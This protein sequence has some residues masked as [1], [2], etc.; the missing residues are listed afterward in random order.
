[1]SRLI[2]K[3]S[4]DDIDTFIN[5]YVNAY[6]GAIT[7]SFSKEKKKEEWIK[8]NNKPNINLYG[9]F[10]DDKLV[11]GMILY[12]FEM[13]LY[14][15]HIMK[16]GGIGEVC[17]D[18]LYK[19]EHV[20]KDL[21]EF[22]HNYY[23]DRGYC[24][25]CLYPFRP[26]FYAKMGYGIGQKMSQ[27]R[28]EPKA[29]PTTSKQNVF[30]LSPSDS[31]AVFEFFNRYASSTH[32]MILR[33]KENFEPMLK[34]GRTLG[35][36]ENESLL[37]YLFFRF[38][39]V[40]GGTWLQN[41]IQILELVYESPEALRGLLT[42]LATQQDQINK[43]IYNT[44]D[45]SFQHLLIEPRSKPNI[46]HIF[47]ESNLQGVG[48]MYRVINTSK[49]F[50][51]L[52][53]HNFGHQTVKLRITINDSFL[54]ENNGS[55]VVHFTEG[56]PIVLEEDKYEVEI[57][58]NIDHFSSLVMGAINFK[59]L[60]KYGLVK[61][62]NPVYLETVNALFLTESPPVTFEVF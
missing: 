11:G 58:I 34:S 30:Y 13:N 46:F 19:K 53:D 8:T 25:T 52:K 3:L 7:P 39:K 38:K 9:C 54:P 4:D 43:V 42:F 12:D 26:D 57:R 60:Y 41:D 23:Y 50:R 10:Q 6:P 28:F 31:T 22:A 15:K 27:Y 1:M 35:Y 49:F 33:S 20:S 29:L 47:Q 5:I 32:G 45:S 36:W 62:T 16:S 2:K 44:F 48:I 40:Q 18:L 21:M 61:I 51:L 24:L 14:S 17:V 55:I 56:K 37:G 59:K